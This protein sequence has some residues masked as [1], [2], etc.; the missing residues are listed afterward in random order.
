MLL[1]QLF[2]LYPAF[3]QTKQVT[4]K[5]TVTNENATAMTGVTVLA[6]N[7]KT[8]SKKSTQTDSKGN[9]SFDNLDAEATY[10]ITFSHIGF[11]EKA[12]NGYHPDATALTIK[13]EPSANTA[14][15]VVVV[16]YGKSTKKDVTGSVKS[17]K[18]ADF[19]KGII[20][21][22]EQLLQGKVAG[23][24]ITSA[25]GEPGAYSTISIRGLGGIRTGSTPLFVVDGVPLDN[26]S[27]GGAINPLA[28]I[29]PQDIESMDV[30]KDAS[31][32]AIYG[33]RGANG[34][35]IVT[36]KKGKS[37]FTSVNYSFNGGISKMANA[38]PVYS[39]DAYK[40][41][42]TEINGDLE[43]FGGNTDWQKE[44]TRTGYT[45]N[46]NISLSGGTNKFNYFGSFG[47]Q[48]Q[49]GILK[50][51]DLKR[52]NGRMNMSQKLL[53]DKLMIDVN[54]TA[55]NTV[56]VRPNIAGLIGSA[57]TTN[58]TIP[59]YGADGKPYTFESDINPLLLLDLEKDLTTTN[60][61]LGNISGTLTI[62]KGLTYKLNFGIDNS[63][64]T[65]DIQSLPN[66]KPL[67]DGSLVTYNT[68]N[69]NYLVENYLTW[70]AAFNKHKLTLLAGHS[71][72]KIFLQG[73]SN[74]INKFPLNDLEPMY[75]PGLGQEMTLVANRPTGYATINELQSFF[76]RANYQYNEKYL[77]TA[78]LRADGSSKFGSNNKYGVFPSFSGAWIISKESFL[79]NGPFYNL[80][81]RAGW[82]QTGNQ[83]IPAKVTQ[84]LSN[85]T[86]AAS[87]SYPLYPS[88]TYPVG[89]DFVR[90]ANPNIQWEVS[91]QTDIGLDFELL[92][93]ALSGTLDYFKKV[94]NNILVQVPPGDPVQPA[95]TT[96][97]NVDGMKITNQGFEA[98][99]NYRHTT[100]SGFS[101]T[102]G[103]NITYMKNE[104]TNSPFSVIYTGAANLAGQTDLYLN[105]FVNGHPI[106][107]FYLLDF[108]GVDG[109][110]DNKFR[111]V[112]N[113]GTISLDKDRVVMGS[114]MPKFIYNAYF[115]VGY[116]NFDLAANLNGVS[117][118]KIYDLMANGYFNL[119]QFAKGVNSTPEALSIPKES[120]GNSTQPSSR[121]LKDGKYLRLNN[122]AIGYNFNPAS[123]G[124]SR[125]VTAL[126]VSFTGQNL[127]VITPYNG[128]DPEVNTD[129]SN[130]GITSYG[131]DYQS[132]P[133]ARSFLLGVNVTF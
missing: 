22:P 111:D 46:H 71:Y 48:I 15:E 42:L 65:R 131:I 34:V 128:Y 53:E 114:A 57:L 84:A 80:K 26:S 110:G 92:K 118:N 120:R 82:G 4:V 33:A 101:Y 5:G 117:G 20:N 130:N 121:Y 31:A 93:G 44:I 108:Q 100:R 47:M 45:Q 70:N 62:L 1:A 87:S 96:W 16:G 58:P 52:Y 94:S 126:R 105:G 60:R 123:L 112:D 51:N 73:R 107:S 83:E 67:R 3:A 69:R 13:L 104:V 109:N 98:D 81:L 54:L 115:N 95:S 29:N 113:S 106:G 91:D 36:T 59:A 28:F 102:I 41:T 30:L 127:F 88:G 43:D 8:P 129:K 90:L 55:N 97:T 35:V 24:S 68:Y 72:Q 17:V 116:K 79:E 75:N 50:K 38:L 25:S 66:T 49:Q 12:I 7:E 99:L 77:L 78:T 11:S 63:S 122:L 85:S 125:W 89:T 37:G 14:E 56:N 21:S 2:L 124:L 10:T 32:T 103:G 23:V 40:K 74:S 19:N 64:G 9:F 61:V 76:G 6:V 86:N 133:K 119:T 27:T 18:S 39:A 132:Y